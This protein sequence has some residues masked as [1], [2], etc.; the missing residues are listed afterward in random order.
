MDSDV[1]LSV[2]PISDEQFLPI[3]D[4]RP[5]TGHGNSWTWDQVKKGLFPPLS[6]IGRSARW[7]RSQVVKWQAEQIR[8][9]LESEA[10]L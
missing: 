2:D 1:R 5:Y 10:Q 9:N 6:H 8:R 7:L 3:T 4:L